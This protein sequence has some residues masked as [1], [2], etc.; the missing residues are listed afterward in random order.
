MPCRSRRRAH[1]HLVA[2]DQPHVVRHARAAVHL[3]LRPHLQLIGAA[4][5][6]PGLPV[7]ID[8]RRVAGRLDTQPR[9]FRPRA[10]EHGSRGP[11]RSVVRMHEP[12][13][14]SRRRARWLRLR[15]ELQVLA[16]SGHFQRT[17]CSRYGQQQL[18]G[19]GV[20]EPE[21]VRR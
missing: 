19:V 15:S 9:A 5:R 1:V 4:L 17:L 13:G 2:V 12:V 8:V 7:E 16:S 10:A 14:T 3:V 11:L 21:F 20:V 18:G 6:V